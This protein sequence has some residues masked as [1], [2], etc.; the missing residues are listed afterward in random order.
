MLAVLPRRGIGKAGVAAGPVAME[1]GA[2]IPTARILRDVAAER[3]GVADLRA[4]HAAGRIRQHLVLAAD[5]RIGGDLGERRERAD[6]DPVRSLADAFELRDGAEIHHHLGPFDA[7]LEPVEAV[8]AAGHLPDVLAA[9]IEQRERVR[10]L[11]RLQK[12]ET[13]H[14]IPNHGASPY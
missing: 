6:L 13:G 14:H 1:A 4:R 5:D 9:T 11:G 8:I 10:Q 12:L 2:V 7:V 3:G